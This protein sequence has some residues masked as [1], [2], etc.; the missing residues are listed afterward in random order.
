MNHSAQERLGSPS[1]GKNLKQGITLIL[2]FPV[3]AKDN[4]IMI[5]P[6]L[7]KLTESQMKSVAEAMDGELI[8]IKLE[9]HCRIPD[10]PLCITKDCY[11]PAI[12]NADTCQDHSYYK[13]IPLFS[14]NGQRI[15]S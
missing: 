15:Q 8:Y 9:S 7:L 2:Q 13:N 4:E 10:N 11:N 14:T 12:E 1:M 5:D 3:I 6:K